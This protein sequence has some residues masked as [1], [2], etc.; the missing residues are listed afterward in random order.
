M[1]SATQRFFAIPELLEQMFLTL[2]DQPI[3]T[4]SLT[5]VKE[6]FV[7]QRVNRTFAA[8]I[9]GSQGLRYKMGLRAHLPNAQHR[10]VLHIAVV[11]IAQGEFIIAPFKFC[12]RSTI[13]YTRLSTNSNTMWLAFRVSADCFAEEYQGTL[14]FRAGLQVTNG[15][16][17][18]GQHESW[19]QLRLSAR[20]EPITVIVFVSCPRKQVQT[21]ASSGP[22]YEER[23]RFKPGEGTL[24]DL[25]DF[26]EQI[27]R[28]TRIEH[29]LGVVR[30][31]GEYWADVRPKKKLGRD[32]WRIVV[33]A[34]RCSALL[35]L[36][37]AGRW[38][39]A[40]MKG[41]PLVLSVLLWLLGSLWVA[42][43]ARAVMEAGMSRKD[44]EDKK[45]VRALPIFN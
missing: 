33:L 1:A 28:K 22:F 7:L 17:Y 20:D 13:E 41:H 3:P 14:G 24:G 8:T 21:D 10:S 35:M 11:R 12:P 43:S 30:Y 2:N 4:A 26:F 16:L 32:W 39:W 23:V 25:A 34:S 38:I 18:R 42:G 9:R 15:C 29:D 37:I 40:S 27:G 44:L 5:S 36:Y 6:L 19:R 45:G 31:S